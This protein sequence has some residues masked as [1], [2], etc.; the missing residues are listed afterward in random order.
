MVH[1]NLTSFHCIGVVLV[2]INEPSIS[3]L[4]VMRTSCCGQV[5]LTFDRF[6]KITWHVVSQGKVVKQQSFLKMCM[7]VN[8]FRRH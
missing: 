2:F 3:M 7:C 8:G 6:F 5:L 1:A 4:E